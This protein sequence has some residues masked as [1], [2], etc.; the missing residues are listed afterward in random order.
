MILCPA[1][2]TVPVATPWLGRCRCSLFREIPFMG[3][4]A[5]VYGPETSG[6]CLMRTENGQVC[7]RLSG[8]TDY[9]L[10]GLGTGGIEEAKK[11][12]DDEMLA[13]QIMES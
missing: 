7:F 1:C 10:T 9:R 8:E 11:L 3:K 5:F 6:R 2:G 4:A 13:A 12:V